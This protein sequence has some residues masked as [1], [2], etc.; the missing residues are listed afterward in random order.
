MLLPIYGS[1]FKELNKYIYMILTLNEL[2]ELYYGTQDEAFKDVPVMSPFKS[3]K[4]LETRTHTFYCDPK[5]RKLV[6]IR[7]SFKN[8]GVTNFKITPA[9]SL[10]YVELEVGG[11]RFGRCILF[12]KLHNEVK[13]DL[14]SDTNVFPILEFHDICIIFE[15][16]ESASI[17]VSYDI[18]ELETPYDDKTYYSMLIKQEQY[19]GD[20]LLKDGIIKLN[21]NHPI[22][23]IYAFL[24]DDVEDARIILNNTDHNLVLTRKDN[25]YYYNFGE[26]TTI[27]FS[28]VD[29]VK[30]VVKTTVP[31]PTFTTD[32]Y[33][34]SKQMVM[35]LQNMAGLKFSK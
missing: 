26:I 3:K 18:V 14:I 28:R 16:C 19:T 30:L 10:N 5:E 9:S 22:I 17:T 23:C 11:Q 33:A 2:H 13:L 35:I 31:H 34:I 24:P 6:K 4:V 1:L 21:Y 32:V 12:T 7:Y 15:T 8:Q 20:E 25:Y 27:N 29:N